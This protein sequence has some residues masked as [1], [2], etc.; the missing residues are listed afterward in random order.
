MIFKDK[1]VIITGGSDGCGAAAARMF[2]DA[3]ANLML[4]ARKPSADMF[5]FIFNHFSIK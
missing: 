4:V 2:A 1:T 3:G 5:S